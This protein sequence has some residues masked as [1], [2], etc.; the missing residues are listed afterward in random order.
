MELRELFE[1]PTIDELVE[2]ARVHFAE[3][4]EAY[5]RVFR[6]EDFMSYWDDLVRA[7][8]RH[9]AVRVQW[10]EKKTLPGLML[11]SVKLV[12]VSCGEHCD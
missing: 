5:Y 2:E 8:V 9:D 6:P 4:G 1:L 11:D 3:T 12:I 7:K 10:T